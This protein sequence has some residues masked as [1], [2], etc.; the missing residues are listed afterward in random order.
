MVE[1]QIVFANNFAR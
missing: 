1:A